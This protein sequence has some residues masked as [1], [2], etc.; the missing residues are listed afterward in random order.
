MNQYFVLIFLIYE[1]SIKKTNFA[2]AKNLAEIS[3]I[4]S[5]STKYF[6]SRAW[7]ST[8]NHSN[9]DSKTCKR[10]RKH[11]TATKDVFSPIILLKFSHNLKTCNIFV[12]WIHFINTVCVFFSVE[13]R[14]C[15]WKHT[16]FEIILTFSIKL[17]GRLWENLGNFCQMFRDGKIFFLVWT[18][19]YW[20]YQHAILIHSLLFTLRNLAFSFCASDL[21]RLKNTLFE[22]F[23]CFKAD[24]YCPRY[25]L[26]LKKVKFLQKLTLNVPESNL[27]NNPKVRF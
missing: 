11:K 16:V 8:Q 23:K 10:I 13:W 2:I 14:K 12:T 4:F 27:L 24:W 22:T 6:P 26:V 15:N 1:C 7:I 3:K 9:S 18:L 20:E 21:T 25:F 17:I 19:I 5:Q